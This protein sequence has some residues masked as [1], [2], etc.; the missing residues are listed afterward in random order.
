MGNKG[1]ESGCVCLYIDHPVWLCVCVCVR[2]G[3]VWAVSWQF[4]SIV[5]MFDF[6]LCSFTF[7]KGHI[8]ATVRS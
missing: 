2:S 4:F 7:S 6:F 8:L 5:L 1:T 3:R